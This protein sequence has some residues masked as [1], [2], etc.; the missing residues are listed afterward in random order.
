[1]SSFRPD[2]FIVAAVAPSPNHDER[3]DGRQ[4]DIILLHYTGMQT[5]EAALERLCSPQS[6]VS[7]HYVVFEDGR[8]VQC[9]PET[10]RAWHAGESF[11]AGETDINSR[12]IGIE[13]VNPGH[14]FGYP[15]FPKRQ[16]DVV[17]ALCKDIVKRHKIRADRVLAHSDVAPARKQDPGEKFP[18]AELHKAGIGHWQKPAPI[19]GKSGFKRGDRSTEIRAAQQMLRSYGYGLSV[20]GIFDK[21]TEEAVAAFQRHFRPKRVDGMLDAS[22][23]STLE[24]ILRTRPRRA[25]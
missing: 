19:S 22:T 7:A 5:G 11:W 24:K 13:I 21:E 14:D 4:A 23:H 1:M 12:S 18:W 17:I 25:V 3:K 10:R 16:I 15:K 9:V 6:K 2:S 8:I 20:T